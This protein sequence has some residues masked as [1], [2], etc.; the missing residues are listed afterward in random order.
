L[1]FEIV[2]LAPG[3]TEPESSDTVPVSLV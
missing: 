3:I 2:T 1:T